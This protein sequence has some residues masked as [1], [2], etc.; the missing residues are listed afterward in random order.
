MPTI[1]FGCFCL[2]STSELNG[3]LKTSRNSNMLCLSS[4]DEKP[5]EVVSYVSVMNSYYNIA[6]SNIENP[7][8]SFNDFL[9]SYYNS[10]FTQNICD[11][12]LEVAKA[13]GNYTAVYEKLYSEGNTKIT[14]FSNDGGGS[15]SG[16]AN[17]I[18]ENSRDYS[19]TPYTAFA[20]APIYSAFDYSSLKEGDIVW[21][22]ETI[23]FNSGHNALIV[24]MNQDSY[25]GSYIQTVEAVGSGVQRGFL[26][27]QRM[28]QYRCEI[29]RVKGHTSTK[30][31]NAIYFAELQIGKNYNL[32][33]F[34]LNT[35]INSSEWYCSELV[36]A[37]WKYAGI[38]I[39]VKNGS[40]L[41][42]GC[43]PNDIAQSDN[44]EKIPMPYYD[45]LSLSIIAK[46]GNTWSI[47]VYNPTSLG[48]T[49][50]YN[51]KMCFLGDAQNWT[52][53]SDVKSTYISSN[54][55]TTVKIT[56]NWFATSITVSYIVGNYRIISY[57]DNLDTNGSLNVGYA[58]INR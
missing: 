56:E 21:E 16:D 7:S 53:L 3:N 20:R 19:T 11:Y 43:L 31:S 8:I 27:D 35:S 18:L 30:S 46:S 40:Y 29:L 25:Y 13:F 22:T 34:R 55:E 47:K 44:I 5:K 50:Y 28:V 26:D 15:S 37:S 23:L 17:Y 41:Q 6:I 58:T 57:A 48:L 1:I 4:S 39:G 51:S 52:G 10:N 14:T 45:Y 38:D 54:S 42:L 49:V 24:D 2:L 9:N 32:N 12:T 36:Y 33:T